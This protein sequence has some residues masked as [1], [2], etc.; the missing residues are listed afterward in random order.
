[1][2]QTI[3]RS[4]PKGFQSAES[5]VEHG[6]IDDVVPRGELRERV[7]T[8]LAYLMHRAP[9]APVASSEGEV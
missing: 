6:M 7:T 9:T 4:L 8:V 3:R 2:E 1:V 5:L